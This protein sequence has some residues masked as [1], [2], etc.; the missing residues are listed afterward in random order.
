MMLKKPLVAMLT[1]GAFA[2]LPLTACSSPS[3]G[4]AAAAGDKAYKIAFL[5]GLVGD[6]FYISMKCGV[7]KQAK[8]EGVSADTQG[9]QKFDPSLQRPILDSVVASKPD[10]LLISPTDATALQVPIKAAAD[11]GIKVVLVDTTLG[12]PSVA[13]SAIASDNKGGGAEAFAAIKKLNPAGGKVLVVST[14]PGVSTLDERV[15]GFE[16][17]V[18]E[19][20]AFDYV[21]VQ[22]SHNDPA[23]A[24]KLVS[25]ALAKD[26]DIVGI[27][28]GNTASAEGSATGVRQAGM[29]NQVKIVGFDAGPAQIKQLKEGT[30]QALIAQQPEQIGV[31]GVKQAMAA[32]KGAEVTAK[33]QTKF[34]VITQE[35]VDTD[36]ADYVYKS[37]C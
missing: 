8:A 11:A 29:K 23:E 25:A 27:F 6:E 28:A 7:E 3:A 33:I 36:G 20:S 21:G 2:A 5:P 32:L 19:D 13:V 26:P 31:D 30:V 34:K 15:A 1:L 17:A 37:S 9:P 22:Y 16:G 14:D 12:D 35:N 24:A 4:G 18:K 10:A